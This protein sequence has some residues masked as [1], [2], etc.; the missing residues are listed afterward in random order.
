MNA[1]KE[2]R[3]HSYWLHIDLDALD[4]NVMQAVDSPAE[5][6]FEDEHLAEL[7]NFLAP[8]AIGADITI[9]DPYFDPDEKYVSYAVK[10]ISKGLRNLGLMPV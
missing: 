8:G 3:A 1:L 2:S 5:G 7:I 10:I 6:D 4:P 9:F